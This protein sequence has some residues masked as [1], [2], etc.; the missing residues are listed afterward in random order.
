MTKQAGEGYC[1]KTEICHKQEFLFSWHFYTVFGNPFIV[2]IGYPADGAGLQAAWMFSGNDKVDVKT[3]L[4]V[5]TSVR[6]NVE[7]WKLL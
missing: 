4:C 3:I 1:A 2:A 6:I 5:I 7:T